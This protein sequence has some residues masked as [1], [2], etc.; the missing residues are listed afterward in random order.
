MQK[1]RSFVWLFSYKL[2]RR[3]K[4]SN[5][6]KMKKIKKPPAKMGGGSKV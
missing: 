6:I 5:K 1:E 3:G 4:R 2:D